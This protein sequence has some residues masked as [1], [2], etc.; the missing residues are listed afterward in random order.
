MSTETWFRVIQRSTAVWLVGVRKS[1]GGNILLVG[2]DGK[3]RLIARNVGTKTVYTSS[4]VVPSGVWQKLEVHAAIGTTGTFDV[5]LGGTTVPELSRSTN[6]GTSLIGRFAIG[7]PNSGR[8]YSVAFDDIAV[9]SGAGSGGGD[10]A[11]IGRWDSPFDIGVIGVHAVV[12]HTGKVLLFY[13]TETTTKTAQL[14]D[15]TTGQL[16]DVSPPVNL[17]HNMFCSAHVVG[18]DGEVFV[19]GGLQWGATKIGYGTERTAFFDPDTGTWSA[20]PSMAVPRWYP[21]LA[22]L[23]DGDSLILSGD[24]APGVPNGLMERLD[25]GTRTISAEP[26]SAT[27]TMTSYPRMFGLPDGRM[28]RVGSEQRTMFYKPSTST[29]TTGPAMLHGS[30]VRGSFVLLPGLDRI[31]AIGGAAGRHRGDERLRRR[32]SICPRAHPR[33][34]RRDRCTSLEGTSTPCSCLTGRSSRSGAIAGRRTTT[35][36]VL[37]T[38]SYDPATGKWSLMASQVA[39]RAYH[40]TA[41]LLPDGRV[42][43]AGQ[44]SGTQQTTAE[45]YSPPYLFSGTRPTIAG[46]PQVVGYGTSFAIGTPDA[47]TI[48]DVELIRPGSVTHGVSFDQRSVDLRFSTGTGSL[49]VEAPASGR[50]APPGWY[51]VFILRNG[52][53]SVAR[54]MHIS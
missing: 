31:L 54:W 26:A 25:V 47:G 23:P 43:S 28:I 19:A 38:E 34:K 6:L 37:S 30:R 22:T 16:T 49:D 35:I 41:V 44:T 29:W 40:S 48:D 1:G 50:V 20:G 39:P 3:G 32:S 10:P 42:L 2:L 46:A 36:P 13:R 45:I 27:K 53:P 52:V 17:Q 7:D 12:L 33:G 14:F 24:Q 18:P 8:S 9:A 21:T 15:P 5:A 4:T 51:M 11:T